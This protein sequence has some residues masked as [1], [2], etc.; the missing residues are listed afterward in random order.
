MENHA[1]PRG[2]SCA[3][4]LFE[5]N[6]YSTDTTQ[7][8][9]RNIVSPSRGEICRTGNNPGTT[10]LFPPLLLKEMDK[11]IKKAI[12][13]LCIYFYLGNLADAFV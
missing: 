10:R 2:I 4:V 12:L 11:E 1:I 5:Q 3:Y 7:N 6:H 13:Y 8:I 9:Q